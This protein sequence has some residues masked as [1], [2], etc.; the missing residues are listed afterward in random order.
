MSTINDLEPGS[1][2]TLE[3]VLT[4]V[5]ELSR[6]DEAELQAL[7]SD[8]RLSE[9]FPFR[10]AAPRAPVADYED[11][12]ALVEASAKPLGARARARLIQSSMSRP[13]TAAA[14]QV[15]DAS[16][17]FEALVAEFRDIESSAS[18]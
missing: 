5:V 6:R 15:V 3:A 10:P 9:V 2:A 4:A 17:P 7:V 8:G 12:S 16:D 14:F 1:P 13:A 11:E 18:G